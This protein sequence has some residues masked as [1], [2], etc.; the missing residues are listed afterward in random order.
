MST[1][2][3]TSYVTMHIRTCKYVYMAGHICTYLYTYLYTYVHIY[4]YLYIFIYVYIYIYIY[5]YIHKS[6]KK[7]LFLLHIRKDLGRRPADYEHES[8]RIVRQFARNESH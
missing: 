1:C 6:E 3:F 2:V 5:I 4:I 8:T 7:R